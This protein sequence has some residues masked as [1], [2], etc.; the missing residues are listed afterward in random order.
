MHVGL[1]EDLAVV[2]VVAAITGMLTRRMGQPSIL[3]YLLAGLIVGPNIP[4]P[5]FA[6]PHRMKELAEIGVVLVGPC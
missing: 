4:I 1:I 5:L 6:D 3:G 2:S